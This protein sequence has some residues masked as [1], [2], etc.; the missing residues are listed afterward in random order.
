MCK[1]WLEIANAICKPYFERGISA[2]YGSFH[3]TY[4][5]QGLP[6]HFH[7]SYYND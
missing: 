1:V 7:L 4:E 3:R 6:R 5:W 2:Y